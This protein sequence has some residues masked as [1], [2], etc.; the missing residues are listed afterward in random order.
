MPAAYA[1]GIWK[2]IVKS[3][4]YLFLLFRRADDVGEIV[5]YVLFGNGDALE[6]D[7]IAR[8]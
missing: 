8:F 7:I 5:F 6:S 3:T 4:V 1:A 2:F